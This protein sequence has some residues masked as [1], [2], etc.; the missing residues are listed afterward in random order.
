M[1][2]IIKRCNQVEMYRWDSV[3]PAVFQRSG[4]I[5][6]AFLHLGMGDLRQAARHVQML[7]YG[8]NVHPD[9]PLVV[10]EEQLGTCSTK[11]ALICRL[12]HE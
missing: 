12:A 9:N 3:V 11:D 4:K 7:P 6:N 8:R 2:Q 1:D 5:T 10:L